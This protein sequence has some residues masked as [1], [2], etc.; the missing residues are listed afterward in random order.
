MGA[1]GIQSDQKYWWR[2]DYDSS[3]W[4]M[5]CFYPVWELVLGGVKDWKGKCI[6][7]V[8]EV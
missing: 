3:D 2:K 1:I 5:Y 7:G 8:F 6:C 4:T